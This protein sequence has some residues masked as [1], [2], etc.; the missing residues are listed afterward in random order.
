MEGCYKEKNN[1]NKGK[2]DIMKKK[3]L[4]FLG[5]FVIVVFGVT[6]VN[7]SGL[8]KDS[9]KNYLIRNEKMVELSN[10]VEQE[11]LKYDGKYPSYYG[12][13]YIGDNATNLVLQIVEEN[14]PDSQA[15]EFSSY[16][17]VINMDDAIEIEY[18]DNSY[19][20]LQRIYN[21]INEYYEAVNYEISKADFS[22][23]T[24][25][26][27]DVENNSVV[28]SFYDN[29]I[30]TKSVNNNITEARL[31]KKFKEEVINSNAIDFQIGQQMV[32]EATPI[33]A[34]QGLTTKGIPD[35]CS[36]GYRV[37]IGGKAGYITAAHCFN[38]NGDSA[39]GGTVT[40]YQRS[41]KVDAAFVQ[42]NSSYEPVNTLAHP[43][44]GINILNNTMCPILR[45]GG[46]IAHDGITSGYQSGTI[47]STSYSA[48]AN[49]IAFTNLIAVDYVS[50][51]GDSGG[52]VF[53]PSSNGEGLVAG[54]HMG[55]IDSNTKVVINADNIYAAFG[56][57]RY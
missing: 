21:E 48:S 33:K 24:A 51:G 10:K 13:M 1:I 41:G 42:T 9:Y 53:V 11:I 44:N 2:G 26:Y 30:K 54:I 34:G 18:V 6:S 31:S 3:I 7:A 19:A 23:Y 20:E 52:S 27:V 39:T 46:A 17:K 38:G 55:S 4:L 37:K 16:E 15:N 40:K 14:I 45:V 8:S 28:V 36:M 12:G 29:S 5:I 43:K 35:N 47:K 50:A 56:Y 25:H 32:S 22:E 49:G 57:S